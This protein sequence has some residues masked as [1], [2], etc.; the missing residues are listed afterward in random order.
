MLQRTVMRFM[1]PS[2]APMSATSAQIELCK[3]K[4]HKLE[5][6]LPT[7]ATLTA[8]EARKMYFDMKIIR[9]MENT[10]TKLYQE[11]VI[12]GFC[13][14]YSGQEAMCVGLKAAMQPQDSA[15]TAYRAHGWTYV[16]GVSVEGILSELAGRKTGC[17]GG[18]GGSMHT[19]APNFYGGNGIVGAQV[20]LGGGIAFAHKYK[21]DNGVCLALYG[22][23]AANQGQVFETFNIAALWK[24]PC[25]F[26]CENNL[27]G[28]GTSI[29]RASASTDFYTRGDYIPGIL[30]DGW[31][32]VSIREAGKF[33]LEYCRSGNGPLV[34]ELNG[35][36]LA[37]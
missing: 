26:I 27:F 21:K 9:L 11:R 18:K 30:V 4:Y 6:S 25:L 5:P 31:D 12:R 20:P 36:R 33:A 16:M 1:R 14:L 19:Y 28:M 8:D 29:H 2:R 7:T 10:C 22:D 35:Y 23:G 34:M 3:Y 37:A 24:L 17:S 13:H 15:I 32:V